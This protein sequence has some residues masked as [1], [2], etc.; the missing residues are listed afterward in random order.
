MSNITMLYK[1][2]SHQKVQKY[3]FMPAWE[4][5]T[6]LF[7]EGYMWTLDISTQSITV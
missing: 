7:K 5:D 3:K 6:E 1:K 4:K 2:K